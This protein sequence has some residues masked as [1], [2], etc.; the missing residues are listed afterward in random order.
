MKIKSDIC[1][2]RNLQTW[3]AWKRKNNP[4]IYEMTDGLFPYKMTIEP[5]LSHYGF[6]FVGQEETFYE[7]KDK[8]KQANELIDS[9]MGIPG[10]SNDELNEFVYWIHYGSKINSMPMLLNVYGR[11][12]GD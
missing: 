2:K 7:T 12:I 8:R 1:A 11:K 10:T 9:F 6:R 3:N 4:D 5:T